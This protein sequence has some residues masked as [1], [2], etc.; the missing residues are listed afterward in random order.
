MNLFDQG[1]LRYLN[2]EQL[3]KIRSFKVGIAGAGG[4]GSNVA[5]N[6][7]RSGFNK[8]EI[9]DFDTIDPS[10]LN[11]QYYF[12][13]EVGK[14]KVD[15]LKDR[16]LEINS[17]IDVVT[18]NVK[19]SE[20]I[21]ERFF[22]NCYFVVE[23]FDQTS[24]KRAFVEFYQPRA[25]VVVSGNGMAGVLV[26]HRMK[27]NKFKNV[28]IAGDHTTEVG[29]GVPPMAPRVALCAAMMSEVILDLSLSSKE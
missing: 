5:V 24:S 27:L 25:K 17:D 23:A 11:R 10:N 7:V 14:P 12:L 22:K 1:L 3:K 15:T 29:P 18:H 20:E 26:S 19:W 9:L 13:K 16:L 4:L 6:L 21:G 2:P 8:L 28:Y